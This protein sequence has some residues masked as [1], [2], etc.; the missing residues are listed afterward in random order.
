MVK[1]GLAQVSC[2]IA[3]AV[4]CLQANEE[5][6]DLDVVLLA[7]ATD[8]S[9]TMPLVEKILAKYIGPAALNRQFVAGKYIAEL[10]RAY[11][12]KSISIETLDSI[13][14]RHYCELGYPDWLAILSRNCEY[15]TDIDDFR[16][17]FEDEFAYI[18]GLWE[19]SASLEE[20][21]KVYDRGV[22]NSHM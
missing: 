1:S 19:K 17:R 9:E 20:F 7:A 8:D 16:V 21:L 6:D 2:C 11:M 18:A 14:D 15:A 5:G 22:S 13:L 12:A 10:R 3:W 4:D